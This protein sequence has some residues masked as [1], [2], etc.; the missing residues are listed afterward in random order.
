MLYLPGKLTLKHTA[1]L[2]CKEEKGL[3]YQ[4]VF[5]LHETV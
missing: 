2:E 1:S 4:A 3:L 5:S